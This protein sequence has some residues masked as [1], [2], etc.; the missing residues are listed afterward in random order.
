VNKVKKRI[1][2]FVV[3]TKK[4]AE[5]LPLSALRKW[6]ES[7]HQ[8]QCKLAEAPFV[9]VHSAAP[10]RLNCLVTAVSKFQAPSPRNMLLE[11]MGW[12]PEIFL[13]APVTAKT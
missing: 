13:V 2:I 4:G 6:N 1:T 5:W 9:M 7:E 8:L 3:N 11:V 10:S 12:K